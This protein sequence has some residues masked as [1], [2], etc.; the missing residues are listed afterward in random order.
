MDI[1][2]FSDGPTTCAEQFGDLL[3]GY[4]SCLLDLTAL[5]VQ[6]EVGVKNGFQNF[7][8]QVVWMVFL[9]HL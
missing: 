4:Q 2:E 3:Y 9:V 8:D 6:L 7:T 1:L 5:V